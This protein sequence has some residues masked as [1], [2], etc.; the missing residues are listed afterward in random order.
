M[1]AGDCAASDSTESE[2]NLEPNKDP[3]EN[4]LHRMAKVH[5]FLQMW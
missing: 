3:E 1:L 2:N 4:E 5:E